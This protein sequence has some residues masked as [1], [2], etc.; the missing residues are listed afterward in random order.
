LINYT[1]TSAENRLARDL[2][3]FMQFSA[4]SIRQ[5]AKFLSHTP[6]AAGA[7]RTVMGQ[8]SS[9]PLP[10]YMHGKTN[11]PLGYND[12]GEATYLSSI[13][14]PVETLGMIPDVSGDMPDFFRD[15]RLNIASQLQPALKTIASGITGR[16]LYFDTPF[17]SYDKTPEILQ[18]L[19]APERGSIG[20]NYNMLA[21][22][23]L[24]Q[25]LESVIAPIEGALSDKT[26]P[27]QKLVNATSG[28]RIV[29]VDEARA[30]QKMLEQELMSRPDIQQYT[31]LYKNSAD[32][33]TQALL[34]QLKNTKQDLKKKRKA[35]KEQ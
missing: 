3:P 12:K 1:I 27:L 25:P 15:V 14:L 9:G 18:A 35:A 16:D 6:G 4:Q 21:G 19:G 34:Q 26:T 13:G 5:Q 31:T 28:A 30:L 33:E 17:G 2:F 10:P 24:I 29:N 22:T 32:P 11:L 20:R 7:Y 23:G 8:E